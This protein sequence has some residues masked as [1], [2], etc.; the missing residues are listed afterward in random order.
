MIGVVGQNVMAPQL[1]I[2]RLTTVTKFVALRLRNQSYLIIE[3]T[4]LKTSEGLRRPD[5]LASKDDWVL[6]VDTQVVGEQFDLRTA[7]C[8]KI[9]YY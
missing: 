5:I 2:I 6:I 8:N 9:R 7:H 3:E 1:L 4:R